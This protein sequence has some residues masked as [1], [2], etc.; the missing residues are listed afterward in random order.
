VLARGSDD[1]RIAARIHLL[2]AASAR[3]DEAAVR[4]QVAELG[5]V[6]RVRSDLAIAIVDALASARAS[7]EVAAVCKANRGPATVWACLASDR[8]HYDE[9]LAACAALPV[10]QYPDV[11]RVR[12]AD[13]AQRTLLRGLACSERDD[14]FPRPYERGAIPAGTP[15]AAVPIYTRLAATAPERTARCLRKAAAF[16]CLGLLE[17]GRGCLESTAVAQ[18]AS[19]LDPGSELHDFVGELIDLKSREYALLNRGAP[20]AREML[21]HLHV[22]LATILARARQRIGSELWLP[23]YHAAAASM[24]W[25]PDPN[26]TLRDFFPRDV[27]AAICAP[28]AD[29]DCKAACAAAHCPL[30]CTSVRAATAEICKAPPT[31]RPT[32]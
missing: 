3:H 20:G 28:S 12:S 30:S 29:A 19:T 1:T 9:N 17:T 24:L 4:A 16:T 18:Y 26:L 14:P 5:R 6:E 21:F 2:R 22:I 13:A 27:R 11:E 15:S 25:S 23:A 31:A 7:G 10:L 8:E 32:P